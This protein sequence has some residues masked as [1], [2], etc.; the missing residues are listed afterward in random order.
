MQARILW[1]E[2]KRA[3]GPSFMSGLRQKGYELH[4]VPT[5]D[6]ALDILPDLDPDLLVLNAASFR[7]SGVRICRSVRQLSNGLPILLINDAQHPL[8]KEDICANTILTLPFTLRKLLNRIVPLLPLE[9]KKVIHKGPIRL[10]MEMK[11][12]R[13][14]GKEARLTP[15]LAK[16]LKIL[17][18]HAG[19]VVE[20]E[21]L[22]RQAWDTD[23]TED[24]R[25]L[26]V[27]ISWLR[28]AIEEDPRN[29]R[30]LVT[31]RGLGYR[32]DA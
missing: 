12:V 2:G 26:D 7:S 23:Y 25:T 13:C 30:L 18:E 6:A 8:R 19:S 5:G 10:D 15:R 27:H 24:T 21:A 28:Q 4:I 31:L 22:F 14:H 11:K 32:L 1:I 16:I 29:P 3:E 20:R 9:G 17:M